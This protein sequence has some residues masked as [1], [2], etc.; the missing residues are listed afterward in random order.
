MLAYCIYCSMH[1]DPNANSYV[2]FQF[3]S[4]VFVL[5]WLG[6]FFYLELQPDC[7]KEIRRVDENESNSKLKVNTVTFLNEG[8]LR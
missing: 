1:S 7:F 3:C 6:F 5:L 2:V 4:F 8:H